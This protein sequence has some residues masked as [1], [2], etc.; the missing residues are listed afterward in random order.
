MASNEYHF[1]ITLQYR[2]E[3]D[4]GSF[5]NTVAGTVAARRGDTRQVLFRRVHEEACKTLETDDVAAVL[6][7]DLAPNDL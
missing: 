6:F 7:F 5:T 2:K 3:G 4:P 1:V